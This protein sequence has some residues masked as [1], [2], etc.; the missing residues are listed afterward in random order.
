MK[1]ILLHLL[2][3]R[4]EHRATERGSRL[5]KKTELL[6]ADLYNRPEVLAPKT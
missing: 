5:A 6:N 4:Q 3:Q 2:H 1:E